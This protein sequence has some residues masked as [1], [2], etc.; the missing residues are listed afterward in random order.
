MDSAPYNENLRMMMFAVFET[1]RDGV[2]LIDDHG[3]L[4]YSNPAFG[5]MFDLADIDRFLGGPVEVVF[6]ELPI[7]NPGLIERLPDAPEQLHEWNYDSSEG[8]CAVEIKSTPIQNELGVSLGRV[9]SFVDI[10]EPNRIK[11]YSENSKQLAQSAMVAG[12][13]GVWAW[14]LVGGVV[15]YDAPP[16]MLYG[17]PSRATSLNIEKAFEIVH[18]EDLPRLQHRIDLAIKAGIE[19][20]DAFRINSDDQPTRWIKVRGQIRHDH[21]GNPVEIIGVC[22]DITKQIDIETELIEKT[23]QLNAI[24]SIAAEAIITIDR[25]GIIMSF[26]KAGEQMFGYTPE[27][28]IGQNVSILMPR[29]H[30]QQHNDYIQRYLDTGEAHIIGTGRELIAQKS[31]GSLFP[32]ELLVSEIDHL[33]MFTGLIRDISE[34]RVFEEKLTRAERLNSIGTLTAGLGH[35][36]NNIL[37]PVRARLDLIE[38]SNLSPQVR[39]QIDEISKSTRYLQ[40]LADSLHQLILDPEDG[41]VSG[42]QTDLR[43]W[44][45]HTHTLLSRALPGRVLLSSSIDRDLPPIWIAPHRLTQA[46]LNLLVNSA[47]AVD[48]NDGRVWF[49][50][51]ADSE[52]KAVRLC[53]VD[54]GCGMSKEAQRRAFEPFFTT[55]TRGI[56]TGLGLTLVRTIIS[57]VGGSIEIQSEPGEGTEIVILIPYASASDERNDETLYENLDVTED[58]CRVH[59]YVSVADPRIQSLTEIL[60][61]LAGAYIGNEPHINQPGVDRCIWVTDM[62]NL[63]NRSIQEA[64]DRGCRVI[65]L[66]ECDCDIDDPNFMNL[67]IT[68]HVDSL[69]K[70]I[71]TAM[72]GVSQ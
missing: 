14:D 20:Q 5:V 16:A 32:I 22:F 8:A 47:K 61:E 23:E 26:N 17:F 48:N 39:S 41:D 12:E 13:I 10:P 67:N 63:D 54:N 18:P 53:V 2:V 9:I 7:D 3:M 30:S 72:Q 57:S 55:K 25:D 59:G 68:D 21:L 15:T 51:K 46:V 33:Q 34:R 60:L 50:A 62:T 37:L 44:W 56:G 19:Y 40:D 38:K 6:S 69:R 52:S 28:V 49:Q 35:D 66:G 36:M 64:L 43:S 71:Q 1:A 27:D 24:I 31:D 42:T 45:D 29:P 58:E 65:K 70:A 11:L 4:L